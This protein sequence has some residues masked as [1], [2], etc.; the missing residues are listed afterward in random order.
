MIIGMV[1]IDSSSGVISEPSR[2][3]PTP[4]TFTPDGKGLLCGGVYNDCIRLWDLTKGGEPRSFPGPIGKDNL[5][6]RGM[7]MQ[8]FRADGKCLAFGIALFDLQF[9]AFH[10]QLSSQDLNLHLQS[11]LSD[12]ME[13]VVDVL[14]IPRG[15]TP[16]KILQ[17]LLVILIV[18]SLC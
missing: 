9:L 13:I 4:P 16:V 5:L 18:L 15:S 3:M 1:I 12:R 8:E 14:F 10:L 17:L 11:K 7:D 2:Q 6:I